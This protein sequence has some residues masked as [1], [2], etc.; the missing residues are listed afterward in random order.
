MDPD[1]VGSTKA[2]AVFALGL[3]GLLTGPLVG[4]VIPATLALLLSRRVHRELWVSGGYLT[5]GR[6]LRRGRALAWA[7]IVLAITTLVI[8]VIAALL[9]VA[10]TPGQDFDPGT[11]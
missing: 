7:G 2:R 5:G 1:P 4:G 3:V 8:A 11:N 10:G 9:H 6:W